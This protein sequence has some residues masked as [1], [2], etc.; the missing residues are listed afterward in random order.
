MVKKKTRKGRERSEK[1]WERERMDD[2]LNFWLDSCCNPCFPFIHLAFLL[3]QNLT[4]SF[5]LVN[6]M[7]AKRKKISIEMSQKKRKKNGWEEKTLKQKKCN[8]MCS[9][10]TRKT[11]PFNMTSEREKAERPMLGNSRQGEEEAHRERTRKDEGDRKKVIKWKTKWKGYGSNTIKKKELSL[12]SITR[13]SNS[14]YFFR[15]GREP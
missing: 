12:G 5:I 11:R 7:R 3:F 15:S 14:W 6:E 4:S 1:K 13:L 10:Y 2:F 8:R 9:M